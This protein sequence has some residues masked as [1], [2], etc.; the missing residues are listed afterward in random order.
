MLKQWRAQEGRGKKQFCGIKK[1]IVAGC[2]SHCVT[3]SQKLLNKRYLQ[4][5]GMLCIGANQI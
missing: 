3:R 5:S 1:S 4:F 2:V